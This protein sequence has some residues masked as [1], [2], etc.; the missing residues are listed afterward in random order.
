VLDL[1]PLTEEPNTMRRTL[2]LALLGTAL[3]ATLLPLAPASA[4]CVVVEGGPGG[5]LNACSLAGTPYG[6]AREAAGSPKALPPLVC[7][8]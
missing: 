6:A 4:S 1:E 7:P 3:A 2:S 5:C 8:Q